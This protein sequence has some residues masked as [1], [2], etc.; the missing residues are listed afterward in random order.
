MMIKFK[1][2]ID[3]SNADFAVIGTSPLGA[4]CTSAIKWS[5]TLLYK[6]IWRLLELYNSV[7]KYK[8]TKLSEDRKS[9]ND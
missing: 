1:R 2:S 4:Q 7:I 5:A 3:K 9:I 6:E 8:L